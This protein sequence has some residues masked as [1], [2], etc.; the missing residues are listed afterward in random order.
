MRRV[1]TGV[2]AMSRTLNPRWAAEPSAEEI[3]FKIAD[4]VEVTKLY[5]FSLCYRKIRKILTAE[6]NASPPPN[7][8]GLSA[9]YIDPKFIIFIG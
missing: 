6:T 9:V 5:I 7:I 1:S 8:W 4:P 3:Q 2:L